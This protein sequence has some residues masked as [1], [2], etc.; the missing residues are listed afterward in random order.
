MRI[1]GVGDKSFYVQRNKFL[2]GIQSY[3]DEHIWEETS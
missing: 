1:S 2:Q 3:Y